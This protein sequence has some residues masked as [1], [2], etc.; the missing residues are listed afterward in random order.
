MGLGTRKASMKKSDKNPCL[1]GAYNLVEKMNIEQN[2]QVDY[3]EPH[4]W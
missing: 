1:C 3:I 4:L 2:G